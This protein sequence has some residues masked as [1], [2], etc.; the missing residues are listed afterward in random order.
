MLSHG[1]HEA[2][3]GEPPVDRD[4]LGGPYD[5]QPSVERGRHRRDVS[6]ARL[7]HIQR[8]R[9]DLCE[10]RSEC[11]AMGGGATVGVQDHMCRG[12]SLKCGVQALS[13]SF[14]L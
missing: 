1:G 7:N 3:Q 12:V 9:A 14:F 2:I 5:S 11:V 6:I 10:P 13:T 8:A 4:T